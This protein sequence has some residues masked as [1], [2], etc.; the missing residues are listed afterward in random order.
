MTGLTI[1]KYTISEYRNN[2]PDGTKSVWIQHES[3]EGVQFPVKM[4]GEVIEKFYNKN[5]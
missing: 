1:G 2:Y 4:L 3:G 5:F